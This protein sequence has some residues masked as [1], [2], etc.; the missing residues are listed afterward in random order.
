MKLVMT[1]LVRDEEDIIAE[2]LRYHLS[3]GVDHVIVM[4]NLSRDRTPAILQRFADRGVLTYLPQ[5]QDDYAQSVWVS[6][7][8]ALAHDRFAAD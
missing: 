8:A 7:M 2:H 6:E 5:T 3:V 1:L 4:D